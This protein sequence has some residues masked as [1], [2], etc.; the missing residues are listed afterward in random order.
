MDEQDY[1]KLIIECV[2][3]IKS[4]SA[5]EYLYTFIKHFLRKWGVTLTSF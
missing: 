5:L 4:V 2:E 3:D 1:K